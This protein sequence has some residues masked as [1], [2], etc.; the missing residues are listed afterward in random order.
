MAVVHTVPTEKAEPMFVFLF[1]STIN[2]GPGCNCGRNA[3]G[4]RGLTIREKVGV[5]LGE[6]DQ[7]ILLLEPEFREF[8]ACSHNSSLL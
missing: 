6:R 7:L 8:P 1:M 2:V 5:A 3:Q 4:E